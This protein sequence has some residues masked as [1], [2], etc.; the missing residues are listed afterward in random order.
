MR[1]NDS[2]A[3][4]GVNQSIRKIGIPSLLL[5]NNNRI[6]AELQS[7][8]CALTDQ[9]KQV[10]FS[11][12][13]NERERQILAFCEQSLEKLNKTLNKTYKEGKEISK[14]DETSKRL[15]RLMPVKLAMTQLI[16]AIKKRDYLILQSDQLV[17]IDQIKAI[18]PD[19]VQFADDI[20][21]FRAF[22]KGIFSM[23]FRQESPSEDIFVLPKLPNT[24]KC[25]RA[26]RCIL[27]TPRGTSP[28]HP[29]KDLSQNQTGFD[30]I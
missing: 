30:D 21:E 3:L 27:S 14:L 5:A 9:Q 11:E 13:P 2:K 18:F 10:I 26:D 22:Q 1:A 8:A 28:T 19:I 23:Q 24:S 25:S 4:R 17:E 29:S 15:K 12:Q 16:R 7:S 6:F 20:K